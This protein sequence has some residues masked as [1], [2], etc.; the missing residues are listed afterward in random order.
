MRDKE[1]FERVS[2]VNVKNKLHLHEIYSKGDVIYVRCPICESKK[3]AMK[4]IISNNSY[5]CKNCGERGYSVGLYARCS[6]LT[7]KEAY[8]KL[9]NTEANIQNSLQSSLIIN[10]KKNDDELDSVYQAFLKLLTLSSEHTMQLL[11]LGF[12]IEDIERIGFK[13]IP[14]DEKNKLVICKK[15]IDD[16]FDLDR[17]PGFYQDKKFRWNFNSHEG[18]F[19]PI[20][21]NCRIVSLRIHLD[22]VYNTDT[23]DIW[24]SSVNKYN[25]TK[26]NNSIMTLLPE[27][28]R[29][30]LIND[31]KRVNDIII[32]SEMLLAYRIQSE[33][34]DKIV[35]RNSKCYYKN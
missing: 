22:N 21:N 11:K 1:F 12:T 18:I 7:N 27:Q 28:N 26:T 23:T 4:L 15:L 30:Q 16:G 3:G 9:I 25:G 34:K 13:T 19:V 2:I 10:T 6:Y 31:N 32:A 24:F 20:I 14:T 5:I 17:I 35:I 29:L 33:Y 8:K